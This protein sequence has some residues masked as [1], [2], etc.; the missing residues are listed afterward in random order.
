MIPNI[1]DPDQT[2]FIPGR[3]SFY[4]MQ[5]LFNV[6]YSSHSPRHPEIVVSLDAEKAF[7]RVEWEYL[8]TVLKKF[9][10]GSA[11][12]SWVKIIYSS[13]LASVCTNLVTSSYFQLHRGTRQGCCLSP[14]LFDIAIEPLAIALRKEDKV[15]GVTRTTKIHKVSL[16]ADDLLLYL[17][18]PMNSFGRISGYKLN[19]SKSTLFPINRLARALDL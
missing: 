8:F 10:F 2:G 19:F 7:D 16:Y 13:P 1:I 12:I 9:G 17:S 6:L 4:N 5:R 3:Q 14:F 15:V 11:F 18:N